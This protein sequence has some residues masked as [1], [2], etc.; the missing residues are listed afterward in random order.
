MHWDRD[1]PD[2]PPFDPSVVCARC[3]QV[4]HTKQNCRAM[5]CNL[6]QKYGHGANRCPNRAPSGGQAPQVPDATTRA[7]NA[8]YTPHANVSTAAAAS[9]QGTN[10]G[11][12]QGQGQGP[13]PGPTANDC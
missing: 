5:E 6:C 4:G 7:S 12:Q 1:C 11:F 2:K 9:N 10:S 13:W 3:G 8:A